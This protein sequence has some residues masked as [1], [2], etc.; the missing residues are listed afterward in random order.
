MIK[1]TQFHVIFNNFS[2]PKIKKMNNSVKLTAIVLFSI[3][4]QQLYSQ[5]QQNLINSSIRRDIK[6]DFI[7]LSNT[8][9]IVSADGNLLV[10]G[11][12]TRP[13]SLNGLVYE[14]LLIKMNT[15][16]EIIWKKTY[17]SDYQGILAAYQYTKIIELHDE[18]ILLGG[19]IINSITKNQDL[20]ITKTDKYGNL[21]WNNTYRD[22]NTPLDAGGSS[23]LFNLYLI[24]ED[25]INHHLYIGGS[26]SNIFGETKPVVIRL[27][28]HGQIH[29]S[30]SYDS[31][32][33]AEFIVGI[34]VLINE[35]RLFVNTE[36]YNEEVE[37]Y[38]HYIGVY[39]LNKGNG[40]LKEKNFWK[41]NY[42]TS[43]VD[44]YPQSA[45]LTKDIDGNYLIAGPS[46]GF[47]SDP[48]GSGPFFHITVM[49]I[50]NSLNFKKAYSY[51]SN[52]LKESK[53]SFDKFR[54]GLLSMK[55]YFSDDTLRIFQLKDTQ[56]LKGRKIDTLGIRFNGYINW[57]NHQNFDFIFLEK[58]KANSDLSLHVLKI[59]KND[60][61]SCTGSPEDELSVI[62]FSFIQIPATPV[63]VTDNQL[64]SVGIRQIRDTMYSF[65]NEM[66]CYQQHEENELTSQEKIDNKQYLS[67]DMVLGTGNKVGLVYPNPFVNEIKVSLQCEKISKAVIQI[68]SA[69]GTVVLTK[70]QYVNK[71]KNVFT[72]SETDRL[73][74]NI[75][76]IK[77]II[78]E[79]IYIEKILKS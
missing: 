70:L 73:S 7:R 16:G 10:T 56:V 37:T 78:D 72:I 77:V 15:S 6:S 38:Q 14:G 52:K 41:S 17:V 23:T 34:D 25:D 12:Y 2:L 35:I 79:K 45:G 27:N 76:F 26:L 24:K 53:I 64:L 63:I 58:T 19:Y 36:S 5:T 44:F 32:P 71:G 57:V 49:E 42:S 69:D 48:N 67:N 18:S 65:S 30:K 59:H 47:I 75:Y 21:I 11:I 39:T 74:K 43:D 50:D 22:I 8:E 61:S 4:T 33:Y 66:I 68:I 3:L 51:S 13:D 20:L 29:W 1:R 46:G 55:N 62:N 54:N 31:G 28:P 9:A 40:N 60:T